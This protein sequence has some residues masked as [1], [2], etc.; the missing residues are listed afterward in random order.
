MKVTS[1]P[2]VRLSRLSAPVAQ[3]DLFNKR[4]ERT[5]RLNRA[6]DGLAERH[7][8]QLVK[9]AGFLS[10]TPDTVTHEGRE[11]TR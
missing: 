11:V 4:P 5:R 10:K 7:G 3:L 2:S 9:P 6:L 8:S 1:V